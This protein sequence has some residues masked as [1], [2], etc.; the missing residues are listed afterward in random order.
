MVLNKIKESQYNNSMKQLKR[1]HIEVSELKR[2]I[3]DSLLNPNSEYYSNVEGDVEDAEAKLAEL[4][5]LEQFGG[6]LDVAQKVIDVKVFQPIHGWVFFFTSLSEVEY[7]KGEDF[8]RLMIDG[9]TV[10]KIPVDL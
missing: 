6:Q 9:V 5:K 7:E 4:I 8:I 3:K 2:L 1:F 10:A